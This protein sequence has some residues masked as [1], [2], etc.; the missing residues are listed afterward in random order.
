MACQYVEN[1]AELFACLGWLRILLLRDIQ[2]TFGAAGA[3]R[4][5]GG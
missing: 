1:W 4:K 5:T 3:E 2:R